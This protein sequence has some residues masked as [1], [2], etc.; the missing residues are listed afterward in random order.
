MF[1]VSPPAKEP[2]LNGENSENGGVATIFKVFRVSPQV[3]KLEK[4]KIQN[5]GNTSGFLIF[6]V[7]RVWLPAHRLGQNSEYGFGTTILKVFRVSSPGHVTGPNFENSETGG[8]TTIF[9]VFQSFAP[10]PMCQG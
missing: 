10:R 8:G 6:I 7:F 1:R 3:M 5:V 2:V 4:T 9:K